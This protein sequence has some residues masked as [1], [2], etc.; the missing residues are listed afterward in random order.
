MEK[1]YSFEQKR[2]LKEQQRKRKERRN[3]RIIGM[4]S[5]IIVVTLFIT[6]LHI[7]ANKERVCTIH[8]IENN[9]V[10]VRHPNNKLYGFITDKPEFYEKREID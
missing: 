6:P 9:R 8:S 7:K 5:L 4:I 2:M 1:N 3:K 10:I